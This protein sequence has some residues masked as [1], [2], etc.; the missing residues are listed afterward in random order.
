MEEY[1]GPNSYPNYS[2]AWAM[3]GST[4]ATWCINACQGGGQNQG[5]VIR[6]PKGFK[7]KGEIR[8]Q[9]THL[10]DIGPT[11]LEPA[12]TPPPKWVHP[13]QQAPIPATSL[14]S[15]FPAPPPTH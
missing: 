9:Y 13:A 6:W 14:A 5:M 1:G 8:S 10:I 3:A 15:P 12:G 2:V 11:I 7:P 4:P